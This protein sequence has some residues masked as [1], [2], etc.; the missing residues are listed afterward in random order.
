MRLAE[1]R[2]RH[3]NPTLMDSYTRHRAAGMNLAD[4]M[5]A[6]AMDGWRQENRGRARP[7]GNAPE[8]QRE[9]P[10][11][12]GSNADDLRAAVRAELAHLAAGVD[13]DLVDRLA[14][15]WRSAGHAPAADAATA[16]ADAA[17]QLRAEAQLGGPISGTATLRHGV[18]HPSDHLRP[19]ARIH[20]DTIEL[21]VRSTSATA[22]FVAD[23][24]D[25][26]ATD[27][28]ARQADADHLSGLADRN[29]RQ[30][31][32]DNGEPDLLATTADEHRVGLLAGQVH[33][34]RAEHDQAVAEQQRRLAR[35]FPPLTS[36]RPSFS[37]APAPMDPTPRR[38]KTR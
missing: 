35:A 25:Q 2:L 29:N 16:L 22:Q 28:L 18:N 32:L 36:V 19:P 7:H 8:P 5:R 34:D 17:R 26:A 13:P 10:A 33:R 4:A 27:A 38:G 30:A 20:H 21:P 14:R 15:Q 23:T 9:A 1:T 11:I 6:A 37:A 3:L 24:L 31:N 12:A